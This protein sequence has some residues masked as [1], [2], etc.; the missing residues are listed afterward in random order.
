M[1]FRS[2][3]NLG[4]FLNLPCL[5]WFIKEY[6]LTN[7]RKH[8]PV[9]FPGLSGL[10]VMC[11]FHEIHQ[12]GDSGLKS[13]DDECL[14]GNG[15]L[16]CNDE[17]EELEEGLDAKCGTSEECYID[18]GENMGDVP[19]RDESC[20][21]GDGRLDESSG[22][23]GGDDAIDGLAGKIGVGLLVMA[24]VKVVVCLELMVVSMEKSHRFW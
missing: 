10:H 20:P 19:R 24:I 9:S 6:F 18:F 12:I 2:I 8:R 1:R 23:N 13:G 7:R 22:D 15:D 16:Y 5:G 17:V 14:N 11:T 4:W 21:A 3:S